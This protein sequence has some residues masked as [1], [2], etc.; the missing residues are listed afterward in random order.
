MIW[1]ANSIK[2]YKSSL[3]NPSPS[4]PPR[5]PK[6]PR[7]N[8]DFDPAKYCT[9][10]I[11]LKFA[12]L[13]QCYNG[14][15][16]HTKNK[17]P[18]PTIE[19]ELW[20]ALNKARLI[21]P[22]ANPLI[23]DGEVNWEGC[24]FSKSG[25]TDKGVSAFG[26]VV[27]IRVR[28]NRR[29]SEI[30]SKALDG[31]QQDGEHRSDIEIASLPLGLRDKELP[32]SPIVNSW[33]KESLSFDYINDEIPYPQILNRLLPRDI[34]VLAWCPSPPTDFSARFSCRERRYR[35]FFTNPAF[36]PTYGSAGLVD[37]AAVLTV[38]G[39][40][41]RE[42]WLD[43]EAMREGAKKFVGLHD[44]RN[45]CKLDPSKQIDNF[46]RRIFHA[47]IEEVDP[48]T[49]PPGFVALSGFEE[50]A[51][52]CRSML[53]GA[54]GLT[55]APRVF[56]FTLHGSAFLW[57]QVRHMVAI[58]FLIGQ[59][60]E[61]PD[62]VDELLD[63]QK[64]PGKPMY[65]MAEDAPLVLWDC[66]FPREGSYSQEDALEWVYVGEST[67]HD[68]GIAVAS[69]GRS[70]G[71]YGLGGVVDDLWKVWRQ[72]KMDEVL[73]GTLL[74][75][76]AE[77]GNHRSCDSART[78]SG[79]TLIKGTQYSS[80]KV[81]Q[82]GNGPRLVGKYTPVLQKPRMPSVEY[83]NARFAKRK[84]FEQQEEIKERGFRRVAD[85][86]VVDEIE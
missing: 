51:H 52:S 39:K 82:G 53:E 41:K 11:A 86:S 18:L 72:R 40:R 16:Y 35:Y 12:Y 9:R 26:Q 5:R 84:G 64:N 15:E 32:S 57:H 38:S 8:R 78:T 48:S 19:E 44:F 13:G 47:D 65:E 77:Q 28:S 22:T 24:D 36:T 14:L 80:Q 31:T 25:R 4:S 21:F 27:G 34:R 10:L 73:A 37:Q 2:R 63:T 49:G 33:S 68:N 20:K 66:I 6:N 59:G 46:Q 29:L 45:F 42:G 62:L 17:T 75:A 60:L 56:T 81:F 43:I 76:V 71:K 23:G 79:D 3:T 69:S 85:E 67:G 50:Y 74:D 30:Q 7:V 70:N 1:D 61:S 54:T 55:F 83:I 58:L